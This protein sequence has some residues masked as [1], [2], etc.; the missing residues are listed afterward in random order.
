MKIYTKT[1]DLGTTSLISGKRV[2]KSHSRL[3][4]YGT[5]DELNSYVGFCI[6]TLNGKPKAAFKTQVL[7]TL[8]ASQHDLFCIGSRLACDDSKILLGLPKINAKQIHLFEE[9]MD[10]FEIGLKP[11]KNF[12]LPGGNISA[13]SLHVART[14]CRRAERRVAEHLSECPHLKED[15]IY[16]NRLGDYLFVAARFINAKSKSKETLWAKT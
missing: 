6:A 12:I 16:L 10:L 5:I 2:L 14:V 11:L 1:G 8:T 3:H 7:K 15:L 13:A 4:S 9:Q